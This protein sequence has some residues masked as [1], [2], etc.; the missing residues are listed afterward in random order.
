MS[1]K[2][3]EILPVQLTEE[4]LVNIGNELS[5]LQIEK[6]KLESEKAATVKDFND[7]IKSKESQIS[8]LAH[9]INAGIKEVDVECYFS[10][11]DPEP[12]KKS[13]Y[14]IDT[15]ELVR[16]ENMNLL[17]TAE[18]TEDEINS[19]IENAESDPEIP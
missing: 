11:D 4:E 12:G 8:E 3:F 18:P 9:Q 10:L 13:L 17:D 1:E 16:T 15:S 14:R 5:G 2:H 19:A 6:E 7:K